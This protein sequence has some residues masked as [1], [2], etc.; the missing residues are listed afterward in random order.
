MR[1]KNFN[2]FMLTALLMGAVS[3]TEK[4]PE[5]KKPVRN[6]NEKPDASYVFYEA[7]PRVFS[8]SNQLNAINDRLE[9]IKDLGVDVIWLMP[10]CEQGKEKAIGSPYCIKDF[11]KVHPQYGTLDDLKNLV[12]KA[13][14]MGMKV[15]LDWIAN[16]TSWDNPWTKNKG[17]H[18]TDAS[19]NIISPPG[20][21][22]TDVADLN[23]GNADMR[24]AM[25]D[26]MA[27]WVTEAGIDGF[28]CDYAEGVP[29]DFWTDA[30]AYLR[31]LKQDI[32]LLAEGD[33]SWIYEVGFDIM[34][35]WS[36]PS[37][38]ENVFGGKSGVSTIF[39]SYNNDMKN[40]P[41]GKTRMRY[42][43]NHDT[44]SEE[45]PISRYGGEKGSMAAFVLTTMLEGCPLIYS[46]QEV[47]YS[48]SL[49]FFNNNVMK[50]DSNK[51]YTDEYIKVMEAFNSTRDVRVGAPQLA[52]TGNVAKL[53]FTNSIDEA[54][55]VMVNTKNEKATVNVPFAIAGMEVTDLM[56]DQKVVAES[57]ID[58][59]PYQYLIY[60]K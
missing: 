9:D 1:L 2:I 15:I 45:S 14:G 29:Q 26:A 34:Y 10:I 46:S 60:R 36:F 50:W 52:N 40:V 21:N 56:T 30:L 17:W 35:A 22:W 3:C 58:L 31:T 16:H 20:F 38:L 57:S 23:F 5:D 11:T 41:K 27:F 6:P 44:A 33:K 32:I 18:S 51:A 28:R 48:K 49:S 55:V 19:G 42:I 59:D 7:N 12:N 37:A 54:L 39:D 53:T 24:K 25:K 13:H 4:E 43:I 47:G 8:T